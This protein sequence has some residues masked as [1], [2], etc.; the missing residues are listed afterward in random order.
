MN[1]DIKISRA[2]LDEIVKRH[3]MQAVPFATVD[4]VSFIIQTQGGSRYRDN[5]KIGVESAPIILCV[6]VEV[7]KRNDVSSGQPPRNV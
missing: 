6:E 5:E 3:V 4:S 7:N 1:L 2:E